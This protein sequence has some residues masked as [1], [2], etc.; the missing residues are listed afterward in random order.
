MADLEYS[1]EIVDEIL[2]LRR[3]GLSLYE[4]ENFTGICKEDINNVLADNCE[5]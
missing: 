4:I 3:Q 5:Y 1:R 2:Y